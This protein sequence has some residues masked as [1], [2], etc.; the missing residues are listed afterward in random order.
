MLPSKP[1]RQLRV[2]ITRLVPIAFFIGKPANKTNEGTMINPPPIPINPVIAPVI[3]PCKI[4]WGY[5]SFSCEW[6]Y[7][8]FLTIDQPATNMVI[9]KTIMVK[10]DLDKTHVP[11]RNIADGINPSNHLR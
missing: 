11:V 5:L 9:E 3:H 8:F 6:A 4:S 1:T 2:I 7:T 10:R